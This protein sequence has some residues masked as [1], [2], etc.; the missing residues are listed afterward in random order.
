M[1]KI[2]TFIIVTCMVA[3][4]ILGYAK[5]NKLLFFEEEQTINKDD[6][7]A[8]L[9]EKKSEVLSEWKP[10]QSHDDF[11]KQNRDKLPVTEM[12]EQAVVYD[13]IGITIN[14][15]YHTHQV[16]FIP[17]ELKGHCTGIDK[18]GYPTYEEMEFVVLDVNI[19]NLDNINNQE[20]NLMCFVVTKPDNTLHG[21]TTGYVDKINTL[22]NEYDSHRYWLNMEPGSELQTKM[23]VSVP[24]DVISENIEFLVNPKG[25]VTF[26]GAAKFN[27]TF[28]NK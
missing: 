1:K 9:E 24:K 27:V 14:S 26:V 20:F 23:V 13:H 21:C 3:V 19:K 4:I 11:S 22:D 2:I 25:G 18:E 12:G 6:K 7:D 17:E 8:E 15:A 16:T 5:K 10:N 28:E